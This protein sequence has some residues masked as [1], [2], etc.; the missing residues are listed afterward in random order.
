MKRVA[1]LVLALLVG[2]M[3]S[4]GSPSEETRPETFREIFELEDVE[5]SAAAGLARAMDGVERCMRR[6]GHP[7]EQYLVETEV[8]GEQLLFGVLYLEDET[9][10][11]EAGYG[12]TDFQLQVREA[13]DAHPRPPNRGAAE[14]AEETIAAVQ[15]HD[16][17][18]RSCQEAQPG[19]LAYVELSERIGDAAF[20]LPQL[21]FADPRLDAANEQWS[22]CMAESGYAFDSPLDSYNHVMGRV[23]QTWQGD[24]SEH[25][26]TRAEIEEQSRIELL[27]IQSAEDRI[28]RDDLACREQTQV[29]YS[30]VAEE[31]EREQVI[32]HQDEIDRLLELIDP[33]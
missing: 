20:A 14:S 17:D 32:R 12:I 2:V 7:P 5:E 33:D 30:G 16:H 26:M 10:S 21:V 28:A 22:A 23:E 13:F 19:L 29:D 4:C 18:Y 25:F 31:I 15:Q 8:D 9:I 11:P 6:L 24:A 27:E 3:S 1:A